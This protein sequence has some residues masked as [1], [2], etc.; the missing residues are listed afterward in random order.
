MTKAATKSTAA[1]TADEIAKMLGGTPVEI[2]GESFGVTVDPKDGPLVG[3][4]RGREEVE[5]TDPDG[6]ARMSIVHR[7]HPL[8]G[9][10][11]ALPFSVWGTFDLDGKLTDE[12]IDRAVLIE[13]AETIKIKGGKQSMKLY[14]VL[15]AE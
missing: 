3:I 2:E 9:S 8:D 10:D 5:T 1:L 15:A 6:K 7:F 12:L 4:Y 11:S 14:R 13:Y